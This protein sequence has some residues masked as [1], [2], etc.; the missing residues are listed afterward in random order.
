[1]PNPPSPTDKASHA[2]AIW[3]R[4]AVLVAVLIGVCG[5]GPGL[6]LDVREDWGGS[7]AQRID[8]VE[9]M[10]VSGTKVRILGTCVS[11]CTLY[12]G[13]PNTCVS[14]KARLGFHGPSAALPG[15]PL[16]REVFD[17]VSLQMAGYYPGQL[18]GWYLAKG[19]L[20]TEGHYTMTGAQVITMGARACD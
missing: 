17:R 18:R 7:V 1:M 3:R 10:R 6:A 8:R 16:P 13:L 4:C 20:R 5:A 11:A 19:R 9:K 15:L 12:L 2:M 14:P